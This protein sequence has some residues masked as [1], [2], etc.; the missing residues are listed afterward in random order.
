MKTLMEIAVGW[1]LMAFTGFLKDLREVDIVALTLP[2]L[3]RVAL[4][5]KILCWG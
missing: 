1:S 2:L 4:T 5:H 3:A